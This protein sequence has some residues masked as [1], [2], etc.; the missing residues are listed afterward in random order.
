MSADN[1]SSVSAGEDQQ[2]LAI[3]QRQQVLQAEQEDTQKRTFS[4]WINSQLLK[5]PTRTV[6]KEL[7]VDIQDGHILLDLLEV[8]S[9]EQ[10]PRE[11]GRN[12][13]QSRS[14]IASSLS[15]LEKRSIKLINI[16]VE[17]I[18][19]GKPSIV[20]GLIWQIIIHFHIEG[21]ASVLA[22]T[23]D[24]QTVTCDS[25]SVVS[26]TASPLPKRSAKSRW[27][28]S[29]KKILLQ[30]A[31]ERCA[32]AGSINVTD[33]KSSWKNGQAL[34]A[35]IHSLRP[36][37]VDMEK[38][39]VKSN[40][41][42]LQE[43]FKI[44]EEELKIPRL[45]EP[46]DFNVSDPDEKSIM[47]YVAQ[48]L[49]YSKNMEKQTRDTSGSVSKA[50]EWLNL[51]EQTLK[52]LFSEM[53]DE[54]YTNKYQEIL[55]FMRKFNE[56]KRIYL[57]DQALNALKPD[58]Q[59]LIKQSIENI[60]FQIAQWKEQLDRSLPAPLDAIE[61]WLSEIENL[62][63]QTLPE[64]GSHY[65]TMSL[66]QNLSG[67]LKALMSLASSHLES[68]TS[69]KN[70]DD[71]G[72]VLVPTDKTE[73]MKTRMEKI[74]TSN[75]SVLLDYRS[76]GHYV[77]AL[78]EEARPKL[79][80][81]KG[82]YK[83]Q[84]MVEM[85]LK[86]YQE[87]VDDKQFMVHLENAFQKFKELHN[88]LMATDEYL[89]DSEIAQQYEMI[90][91]KYK[92]FATSAQD[93][94]SAMEKVLT[95]WTQFENNMNL[96]TA[97]LDEQHKT[98]PGHA[99]VEIL[100]KWKS[101]HKSLNR[102]CNFLI[103]AT[104]DKMA[105]KLTHRLK[106]LNSRW[107]KYL[108]LYEEQRKTGNSSDTHEEQSS[109]MHERGS[110][111][112][113]DISAQ[114]LRKHVQT[115]QR[116]VVRAHQKIQELLPR[117]DFVLHP[118]EPHLSEKDIKMNFEMSKGDLEHYIT[119]AM[120][121]LGQRVTPEEFISQYEKNLKKFNSQNLNSFLNAAKQMKSIS[122]SAKE[123]LVVDEIS[124][125]LRCR[126][127][128]VYDELE[129]Y[130][131]ELKLHIE[132]KTVNPSCKAVDQPSVDMDSQLTK[133]H[134]ISVSVH[135]NGESTQK[136]DHADGFTLETMLQILEE[137]KHDLE[138]LL[139]S[140]REKLLESPQEAQDISELQSKL[141]ELQTLEVL[142]N[143]QWR[144]LETTSLSAEILMNA[145]KRKNFSETRYKL[146]SEMNSVN[147]ELASRVHSLSV[148]ISVLLPFE[149]E[150]S[151]L[152]ESNL[153][154]PAQA[155]EKF[156]V[157]NIGSV[158]QEIKAFQ[159]SV[160]DQ[161]QQCDTLESAAVIDST[162]PVNGPVV[163]SFVQQ[164]KTQLEA[165]SDTMKDRQILLKDLQNFLSSLSA[166][167]LSIQSAAA[168]SG[169]DK[170]TILQKQQNL[171]LLEL[172]VHRLRQVATELD[173]QLGPANIYLEDPEQ[174]GATSCK[175][176]VDGF[177]SRIEIVRQVIVQELRALED[178]EA[179]GLLTLNGTVRSNF[180][181]DHSVVPGLKDQS[182]EGEI[183]CFPASKINLVLQEIKDVS[184]TFKHEIQQCDSP[185]DPNLS[186]Y[187]QELEATAEV[188]RDREE[189]L[190]ALRHFLSNLEAAKASV[191]AESVTSGVGRDKLEMKLGN[192]EALRIKINLLRQEAEKLDGCLQTADIALEDPEYGGATSCLK[193]IS[194]FFDKLESTKRALE[195]ELQILEEENA[196]LDR[197]KAMY[198]GIEEVQQQADK[199]GLQDPT[200]HALQ[201][202]IK[203]LSKLEKNLECFAEEKMAIFDGIQKLQKTTKA[204]H[205][206]EW[207]ECEMLWED[208]VQ[209]IATSKEQCEV[210]IKLLRDFQSYKTKLM[211]LIQNAET[212]LS[213]QSSYMGKENLQTFFA[214]VQDMKQE[215]D[216]HS[217]GVEELSSICKKLQ[218]QIHKI[219][220]FEESPFQDEA[221]TIIDKCS[222]LKENVFLQITEKLDN[223]NENLGSIIHR[224]SK[225]QNLSNNIEQWSKM[226]KDANDKGD[227]TKEEALSLNAEVADQERHLE[228]IRKL[229]KEIQNLLQSDELPFE[230][231]V[232]ESSLQSKISLLSKFASD[233]AKNAES[234]PITSVPNPPTTCLKDEKLV[235]HV[236]GTLVTNTTDDMSIEVEPEMEQ[237]VGLQ[238]PTPMVSTP[239]SIE[240]QTK[241]P[242]DYS[243]VQSELLGN[244]RVRLSKLKKKKESL[245][246][247]PQPGLQEK[248]KQLESFK[249]L[250]SENM[251]LCAA[252]KALKSHAM[253]FENWEEQWL[254]LLQLNEI[255]MEDLQGTV[256]MLESCVDG[257]RQY[258][259]FSTAL[260]NKMT[261]FNEDLLNFSSSSRENAPCEQ[262]RRKLQELRDQYEILQKDL[263]Q[264][265]QVSEGVKQSTS[266]SGVTRIQGALD[267]CQ[268]K[269]KSF[270]E[271]LDYLKQAIELPTITSKPQK[272]NT[273]KVTK[274]K[275]EI[276]VQPQLEPPSTNQTMMSKEEVLPHV[277]FSD[278]PTG[279]LPVNRTRNH[280]ETPASEMNLGEELCQGLTVLDHSV[281]P[282]SEGLQGLNSETLLAASAAEKPSP[283][284]TSALLSP[285]TG[286]SL[287]SATGQVS[288]VSGEKPKKKKSK[289]GIKVKTEIYSIQPTTEPPL[290]QLSGKQIM[291]SKEEVLPEPLEEFSK[292]S[293]V[294][295][296]PSAN[297]SQ[298]PA[299]ETNLILAYAN[300]SGQLTSEDP[301]SL[302]SE[303][304]L[305]SPAA[306]NHLTTALALNS[307]LPGEPSLLPKAETSP[308]PG[309][310]LA[311]ATVKVSPVTVEKTKKTKKGSKVKTEMRVQPPLESLV[312]QPSENQTIPKGEVSPQLLEYFDKPSE[313]LVPPVAVNHLATTASALVS[314]LPGKPLL[315]PMAET[316]SV[317]VGPLEHVTCVQVSPV[318]VEKTKKTKKSS[319]MRTEINV[320]PQLEPLLLQPGENQTIPEREVSSQL[321]VES[322]DKPTEEL[323]IKPSTNNLET[324]ST[325]MNLRE[326][327][328]LEFATGDHSEQLTFE[329]PL[330]SPSRASQV[331]ASADRS[332]PSGEPLVPATAEVSVPKV[333]GEYVLPTM[334][335]VS[336]SL[337]SGEFIVPAT[338]ETSVSLVSEESLVPATAEDAVSQLQVETLVPATADILVSP[339]PG[340]LA[341]ANVSIPPVLRE[342]VMPGTLSSSVPAP[343]TAKAPIQFSENSFAGAVLHGTTQSILPPSGEHLL[344]SVQGSPDAL[345]TQNKF[346]SEVEHPIHSAAELLKLSSEEPFDALELPVQPTT[347][348]SL[349]AAHVK[350]EVKANPMQDAIEHA[351]HVVENAV[352]MALAH[353]A[354]DL[355]ESES[356]N[357]ELPMQPSD[358]TTDQ[359]LVT[360]RATENVKQRKSSKG[361]KKKK[362]LV[363]SCPVVDHE[364]N[365]LISPVLKASTQDPSEEGLNV[366]HIEKKMNLA[367]LDSLRGSGKVVSDVKEESP[368]ATGQ[369]QILLHDCDIY[370][371]QLETLP[372]GGNDSLRIFALLTT[373]EKRLNQL[374][375]LSDDRKLD[376]QQVSD[377]DGSCFNKDTSDMQ[378][379][380][381]FRELESTSQK[382]LPYYAQFQEEIK[383]ILSNI[384]HIG[385]DQTQ[386]HNTLEKL[387][388]QYKLLCMMDG[389]NLQPEQSPQG[390]H[391]ALLEKNISTFKTQQFNL[392]VTVLE[393]E[394]QDIEKLYDYISQLEFQE[395]TTLREAPDEP[396]QSSELL[397]SKREDLLHQLTALK[398]E[399]KILCQALTKF[400]DALCNARQ[401]YQML[402]KE[403]E[404]LKM[405]PTESHETY[406]ARITC[407]SVK[408]DE[409]K[410]IL[411][412]LK[413]EQANMDGFVFSNEDKEKIVSD[414]QQ[415]EDL[416]EQLEC[417]VQREHDRLTKEAEELAV[418]REKVNY[419]QNIIQGQQD[420]LDQPSP[421]AEDVLKASLGVSADVET[422]KHSF[423]LLRNSCDLQMK[424]T[425][426]S[427]ERQ[428]LENSLDT[429][430]KELESLEERVK[431]RQ[432]TRFQTPDTILDQWQFLKSLYKSYLWVRKCQERA[433]SDQ[434]IA[435]LLENLEKQIIAYKNV[436]RGISDKKSSLESAIEE[437]KH[438][439]EGFNLM[440]SKDFSSFF[441]K[442]QELY[443]EQFIKSTTRLQQLELGQE[444]RKVL[445]SEIEKLKKLLQC[446]EKEATPVIRGIFSATELCEQLNCL[447]A[448]ATE[449][450]E[451]EGLVLTL[452]RNSQSYH[453]ELKNSEQ[454]YLNDV[455]RS[456]KAKARRIRRFEEKT[457]SYTKKLL[458][459][460]N[461]FKE[462]MTFLHHHINALQPIEPKMDDTPLDKDGFENKLQGSQNAI[463]S[464][465]YLS[466]MLNYKELFEENGLY[467]DVS[468]MDNLKKS[469]SAL[470][471]NEEGAGYLKHFGT[472]QSH[473]Q[474]LLE[475]IR[476]MVC[477]LQKESANVASDFDVVAATV[478]YKKVGDICP[479]ITEALD[480]NSKQEAS[481]DT[482]SV[483]EQS[484]K[485]LSDNMNYLHQTVGNVITAYY[486]ANKKESFQHQIKQT[487]YN[488]N[489]I[490]KEFQK[491]FVNKLDESDTHVR[492]ITLK[493][494]AEI[495]TTELQSIRLLGSLPIDDDRKRSEVETLGKQVMEKITEHINTTKEASVFLQNFQE[496]S[497]NVAEHF[498]QF[499][500]KLQ[501]DHSDLSH[502]A[503]QMEIL[504]C[505]RE[506][507]DGAIGVVH[508]IAAQLKSF[509]SVNDQAALDKLL[510][511]IATKK[512][513]LTIMW[514][515]KQSA[516]ASWNKSH[517][518]FKDYKQK[519]HE[520]LQEVEMDIRDTFLRKPTSYKA[521]L[522]QWE[523]SKNLTA[524]IQSYEEDLLKLQKASEELLRNNGDNVLL[525]DKIMASLWDRWFYLL[526]ISRD[527]ELYC[528]EVKQD[529]KLVSELMEREMILLDNCQEE[530]LDNPEVKQPTFQLQST[531][532]DLKRFEENMEMQQLQL[533]L[534][535]HRI[536]NILG[537]ESDADLI[538]VISEIQSMEAK[539]EGLLHKAH[540]NNQEIHAEL[541]GREGL[542]DDISA[543]KKSAQELSST[544][545]N[546]EIT[547]VTEAKT[548]LE[549]L[550][551]LTLSEKEKAKIIMEKLQERYAE[552]VPAELLSHA[553]ECQECLL[554]MEEKVTNEIKQCSPHNIITRKVNEIK[555]GLQDIESR[556]TKKSENIFQAK[557]L[558]K[559]V[560]D[561]VDGWHSKLHALESEIQDMAEEDPSQAQA[562]MDI[563]TEPFNYY[564]QV[565]YLVERRTVNLNKA[566]S[567]L[568]EY[569]EF[570]KSII[571]WIQNTNSLLNEEMKDSSAKVLNKHFNA[572]AMAL[573]DSEQKQQL[574]DTMSS[575]LGV[576][577]VIFETDNTVERLNEVR[578]QVKEL[579]ERILTVLPQIQIFANEVVTIEN[580]VKRMEKS[581][582][583]IKT[584]LTSNEIDDMPPI[585]HH[586]NGQVIL[587][588]ID[589][590]RDT[591]ANIAAYRP[592]LAA[593]ARGVQS[594]YVFKRMRRLLREAEILEKV[595]K[596]QNEL[597]EPIVQEMSELEQE[598]ERLKHLS[599]NFTHET[600][601]IKVRAD[602]LRNQLEGLN[603]NKEAILLSQRSSIIQQ[604]THLELEPQDQD[605]EDILSPV[606]EGV[607][608]IS[609]EGNKAVFLPSVVE[610]A[611]ESILTAEA[612]DKDITDIGLDIDLKAE[613]VSDHPTA[614]MTSDQL[615]Q[616]QLENARQ[617]L[618]DV[619][620][621][622]ILSDCQGKVTKVEL[623]LQAVNLS[624]AQGEEEP[625]MLQNVEQQ[626]SDCQKT[627]QE[628]EKK[629]NSLLEDADYKEEGHGSVLEEAES[630]ARKLKGLK[631]SLENVQV[632]LQ[633]KPGA[634]QG[635]S[636]EITEK[637]KAEKLVQNQEA[638]IPSQTRH[639][640]EVL[641]GQARPQGK[642]CL[643]EDI[644]WSKWQY[645]QKE[646]SHRTKAV[647]LKP[648]YEPEAEKERKVSFNSRLPGRTIKTPLMDDA[649]HL[650]TRLQVLSEEAAAPFTQASALFVWLCSVSQWLQKVEGV[651]DADISQEDAT[652]ELARCE[653]LSDD[654]NT[655]SEEM[656]RKMETLLK[657]ITHEGENIGVLSQCYNDIRNWLVQTHSVALS[658]AKYIREEMEKHNNYQNDIRRMYDMLVKKKSDCIQQLDNRSDREADELLKESLAWDG[659]LQNFDSQVSVLN[660][661]G[662]MF[663]INAYSN[664]EIDK[665]EDVLDDTWR[666]IITKQGQYSEAAIAKSQTDSLLRGVS[667]LVDVGKEKI[668]KSKDYKFRSKESLI[669]HTED[670]KKF[671]SF[672]DGQVLL[673][674]A[675]SSQDST[676]AHCRRE[677]KTVV[678][679]A[680]LLGQKAEAH[681]VHLMGIVKEWDEFDSRYNDLQKHFE[682]LESLV[683]TKT[684][685]EESEERVND[686]IKQ[687]QHIKE[688]MDEKESDFWQVIVTGKRLQSVV[689]FEDL[690]SRIQ[691][692]EQ[693]WSLLTKKVNHELHRLESLGS[694]LA[695]YNKK[696]AELVSWLKSAHQQLSTFK[697]Q[698]L[699]ASQDLDTIRKNVHMFFEFT[700]LVDEKSSLKTSVLSTG[701]QLLRL[702]EADT[703]MLKVK[704]SK[705]EEQWTELISSLPPIQ[706][707]LQQTIDHDRT[708]MLSSYVVLGSYFVKLYT[709][710]NFADADVVTQN[711]AGSCCIK[712]LMEKLSSLQAIDE[713][714]D[715]MGKYNTDLQAVDD[716]AASVS[717]IR[718]CLQK[719]KTLR[720]EMSVKQWVVDFVNQSLLQLSVGDVESQRYERTEFAELLGSLNLQ[721][722]K[723]Q[724][725]LNRKIQQEEQTL[726]RV[727]DQESKRQSISNWFD[728]QQVR[729][730]KLQRPSSLTVAESALAECLHLEEQ[731][732]AKSTLIEELERGEEVAGDPSSFGLLTSTHLGRK[733]DA[734]FSKVL[735]KK[736]SLLS[737]LKHWKL[738]VKKYDTLQEML[739]KLLYLIDQAKR[740]KS[741]LHCI[742][743]QLK[744]L[745][746]AQEEVEQHRENWSEIKAS[747]HGMKGHC[748]PKIFAT[749]EKDY[750]EIQNRW[751]A[752]NEALCSQLQSSSLLLQL[753]EAYSSS[754]QDHAL[755]MKQ[756]QEKCQQLLFSNLSEDREADTLQQRIKDLQVFEQGLQGLR[757]HN[758]QVSELAD[759]VI[760][761]NPAAAD[762]IHSE[763]QNTSH[764]IDHLERSVSSKAAELK[765]LQNEVE[766]FKKDLVKLQSDVKSSADFVGYVCLS[767]KEKQE[768]SEGIKKHLLEL[769]EL[770][771][772]IEHLNEATLTLPLDD[773][774]L[775]SLQNLNRSWEKTGEMA[776]EDCRELRAI[777][778]E[779]NNFI[780]NNEAWIQCLGKMESSLTEGIAGTF[781][782]LQKQQ[783][784]YERLQAE[785]AIN[786]HILP[787]FVNKTL[788]VLESE[789]EE[790]RSEVI[791][792]LTTLK[793]KW[794]NVIRLVQQ[795]NREINVLLKQWWH[796]TTSKQRLEKHLSGV[797][798]ALASIGPQKCHSLINA[799]KL[800]FDFKE[801]Q[802]HVKRLQPVYNTAVESCKDLLS[803]AEL[804]CKE[805][806][807]YHLTELQD[808]WQNT[809]LQLQAALRHFDDTA[810]KKEQFEQYVEDRRT[811]LHDL[812]LS[813][814][815]PLPV[816]YEEL[817]KSK[818]SIK[819][820]E[821]ALDEWGDSLKELDNMK[822]ELSQ[823]IVAEDGVVL[824][825]Q[826]ETLHRQWEE[827]CLRVSMR[828]QEIE[829]RLNAWNVF[830]EKNK[831]LC[832][833]LTQMESKALQT[834]DVN[835]EEMIE[836]LQKDCMEE[837]NL[838][839]ENK[840][841]L[842]QIGD[843]LI[844]ASNK[845][846]STEIENKLNKVNDRWK[847]LFDV[848]GSRVKKLKETLVIIQQLDKNMSNLRTW[849]ARIE[850]ELSKPVIYSICDDQEI[851]R[852]LEEQKDLQ[853]DIELHSAGVASVLNICERLLHDTDAC[854]SETECDSIQQTTRSLDKRWRNICTMSM[855]RRLRI[856][857][858]WRLWQKFLEDYSKFDDWL[859]E[860]EAMAAS[861][862][863]SDV[864]YTKA[865][866][867]QKKF[868]AFQRQIHER[869]TH[870]ELI[871]KQYRRLAREN[872]TDAA[873]RLKQMV[874]EGNRRWDHL[875]R[876]VAAIL[877]RLKHFTSQRE[878]FEGTRDCILVWLTEMDLQLT[879]VEHFS[880]SDIQEKMQQLVGF[881]QEITLNT[882]KIDQLI[883]FGEQL[884]QKSEAMDAV[885]IEDELEE[886]HRYCQEVFG[887]VYR[888]H[889]RLTAKDMNLEEERETS[890]NDTDGEDSREIQNSSWHSTIPDVDTSHQSLCQLM[891][892]P[893]PHERSGCETPV[894][895]DSI[896]LEWDPTV[897][898]GGSSMHENEEESTYYNPLSDVEIPENP[899]AYV[900]MT[901]KTVQASSGKSDIATPTWHSPDKHVTSS[902][903][904]YKGREFVKGL[905]SA[906]TAQ[907]LSDEQASNSSPSMN[908]NEGTS[909]AAAKQ[910][911]DRGLQGLY[912]PETHSGVIERW[913]ILHAQ[914]LSNKR[915]AKQSAQQWQ[916]FYSEL[917]NLTHWLEKTE[918]ELNSTE[919]LKPSR[920]IQELEQKVKNLKDTLKAFDHYKAL[921]LSTN[922][923][924]EELQQAEDMES[925]ELL[926]RLHEVNGHWDK[927]CHK[928]DKWR[929]NL[930]EDLAQCEEFH[931]K[932]HQLLLWLTEAESRRI[933]IQ[934]TDSRG[935]P[936]ALLG[937]Q[938]QL[939][940]LEEQLL[941]RQIEADALQ[942]LSNQ[943]LA[944]SAGDSYI[945]AD[946]RTHVIATKM[947]QVLKQVSQ[948]LKDVQQ[949]LDS[950]SLDD[951]DSARSTTDRMVKVPA[952]SK[953]TSR[954][955]KSDRTQEVPKKPSLFYRVLRA[956]LPL[957][958][959]LLLLLL[960][961][962]MI[963][964][965]EEDYSC[966]QANN[967][968]RSFYPMLRYTNGPPPT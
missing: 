217:E 638:I 133:D 451:I 357:K 435:L 265:S 822:S 677:E 872:R 575:E 885:V 769:R 72:V 102:D 309:G 250:I 41:E 487:L 530:V 326:V 676:S 907:G 931:E 713:L 59:Q 100:S 386:T 528:D 588:N 755:H 472:N 752:A 602:E 718:I 192:L 310:P 601:D 285:A 642:H 893:P 119:S 437:S 919:K 14:N 328:P 342:A 273:K 149:Q 771:A 197:Q 777:E 395:S 398:M 311:T 24:L 298:M 76:S 180:Q 331:P 695:G 248:I 207:E 800:F 234:L 531:V 202:R 237:N 743:H 520:R 42:K 461:E 39:L 69:F 516:L 164:Y 48:F 280:L 955:R 757:A 373:I 814:D 397:L 245:G 788:S 874:H 889:E 747:L 430:Q 6:V 702:K 45:L 681:C 270:L 635:H 434:T 1:G 951:I 596:E 422:I 339:I 261:S 366:E 213:Q 706:E 506:E 583:S 882:N 230:L 365:G 259:L 256:L 251:D 68:L 307:P 456:L 873:S 292:K 436:C 238:S 778:L 515:R 488:L 756:L 25:K 726:E 569:E 156:T 263:A 911:E 843:Q 205:F 404:N 949:S 943:L 553:E 176:M 167:K 296:N 203:Y 503:E 956:A 586:R 225:I 139:Q 523:K 870:L 519:I 906:A 431:D 321:L 140:S 95:C 844:D 604:L 453:G 121:L 232:A 385:G 345:L 347:E 463:L 935:D 820:L 709:T 890:E 905:V 552:I 714:M 144:Q 948:D 282:K 660:E 491:P 896:P 110:I 904:N 833:W 257:H 950:C 787:S 631:I 157:S 211:S 699:D 869:L 692:A 88:Q 739:I 711:I 855:E 174:G 315:K 548:S 21:L 744:R 637:N 621:E 462:K 780:Q 28:T 361:Q 136:E 664:Q 917:N 299:L 590:I 830:N 363:A 794:Q 649:T 546:L 216:G 301:P 411:L 466:Q 417:S 639:S 239:Q 74:L 680:N 550:L 447:K 38:F 848:I 549:E 240:F 615:S 468:A 497:F 868:E 643:S 761:Q 219:K 821:D 260:N 199:I 70:V 188:W 840:L 804:E 645:L 734:L 419:I 117:L 64:S 573:D 564:Q 883:V 15:F 471:L 665:L 94:K 663:S 582:N 613:D 485:M 849:L 394:I 606:T 31:Q 7:Y 356:K 678:H 819:E 802:R 592:I 18:I 846:R 479:L 418:V 936:N 22:A 290:L 229:S 143:Q 253:D 371:R 104:N 30:W 749:M 567:K 283:T 116:N 899:E 539:C 813:V 389:D 401:S 375:M 682:S 449:M 701:N 741:S 538:P 23:D 200:I 478:L 748:S 504:E 465:V 293:A 566:T 79:K 647:P 574:L 288:L 517:L 221:N 380:S 785:I 915:C 774:T 584:I 841:H 111:K 953:D 565:T 2:Q 391:L 112:Q 968:A 185:S 632:M 770:S 764:R 429:L 860:A 107:A 402:S 161:I 159:C 13:F 147:E 274:K 427:S 525:V 598:Q 886:L 654:L 962:C 659:E 235:Q 861:P 759:K 198:K 581:V 545:E 945:E 166:T 189:T 793:E 125:D 66:L 929:E 923:L 412:T 610:E 481:K 16:H 302:P 671:F 720:K 542:M 473:Y 460:C 522:E 796:F 40:E 126:W 657:S 662:R 878:D 493:T 71:D 499:E 963:P 450:E 182:Q 73:E 20:L 611:E 815:E 900:L 758:L 673:L 286:E 629:I 268:C 148:T 305:V 61:S 803:V 624:L 888:F 275:S 571:L 580:E 128:R 220:S 831:E 438:I 691:R 608:S 894:S 618:A 585:E 400:E 364:T 65:N 816:L 712:L 578:S 775:S 696:T 196:L 26:P 851:N 536:K 278:L 12:V 839:S 863:S 707:K 370:R 544:L 529:W 372:D 354:Q 231:Q 103:E 54:T 336:V 492:L 393:R 790:Q 557:E 554:E 518:L 470:K 865:K 496:A 249:N 925:K 480:L 428:D 242:P 685:V 807:Q 382:V 765:L 732:T 17:D 857:E 350:I 338:D 570:L 439:S 474:K 920:S 89:D 359:L 360:S 118:L 124:A 486:A 158:C 123:K 300:E 616:E 853:K 241:S 938:R 511:Q 729:L 862:G 551:K 514:E 625:E 279:E 142:I 600:P 97:W 881:K 277:D 212:L 483:E 131:N 98:Q 206:I 458:S 218:S 193:L 367:D 294:S 558:Q 228:E 383:E 10:L 724:G 406:L 96:I 154:T 201:Q 717:D 155:M 335:E 607:S 603:Q 408:L 922:L 836:K 760:R 620:P 204:K 644:T 343:P 812:K 358:E 170:T 181:A 623:W 295:I 656:R 352:H 946:E 269:M 135:Q 87:F 215:Y 410:I 452:L 351:V 171:G 281:Q 317:P 594:L 838:F 349:E 818:T 781:E 47:T 921:V 753:W 60:T 75:F 341:D 723:M 333:S 940:Q 686:R 715:W 114:S 243:E 772:D 847:H 502:F 850:S 77:L 9:G 442:L 258:D 494:L 44:A 432:L 403:K 521:A 892:P 108:K 82:K 593:S 646:L 746:S 859:K 210:V 387:C 63:S 577:A 809:T 420:L 509:C 576:L 490:D 272:K 287:V 897:D 37:L 99:P 168:D 236:N 392:N 151:V 319:R 884:I 362:L 49:Q 409:E 834:A 446:R 513:V 85:M 267:I 832:D 254:E 710:D 932:S 444:R 378:P 262:K 661:R 369:L 512:S 891:P 674:Q 115:L 226:K 791:L 535:K 914:N 927:A 768:R 187:K 909:G 179:S 875:Q 773:R 426:G 854:A 424:R 330:T 191:E 789:E 476:K 52:K 423:Y 101:V 783:K 445:F 762:V 901:T 134:K 579:Q 11:K 137:Q 703:S 113:T 415:I 413:A 141:Q 667:D 784:I 543:V 469:L 766:I 304:P 407:F 540:R 655:L 651:L 374:E 264:V 533:L 559:K 561:E 524:K 323:V 172:E 556:L 93:A 33:F 534:L 877:R 390:R 750:V 898:V 8:L 837:I 640:G 327:I 767:Q 799:R 484:L 376:V 786:E 627:L 43:A 80:A 150:V 455:L 320:Q 630:L 29:A 704:Q 92:T 572:L 233:E 153:Q 944:S 227:L 433:S 910:S 208:A 952:T 130:V 186:R 19:S 547:D 498:R 291:M 396:G 132:R 322:L 489:S 933:D 912:N 313:G 697:A 792:K 255:F 57:A 679:K 448:K 84:E 457:F 609:K 934:A 965:S 684:L 795:R 817:Q 527:W 913:E 178:K 779:R 344:Q 86:D 184:H 926:G 591:V 823:Y 880:E 731:M 725:E 754:Y 668:L 3:D 887:R 966:A 348:T 62:M 152:C 568:E 441:Q 5:H 716:A 405:A 842:K 829:D 811:S 276:P 35:I 91:S 782:A 722:N 864:L 318:M 827:L 653:K 27:K 599:K 145:S 500:G 776:L 798:A 918:A 289:K 930:Q 658:R 244:L 346:Q 284:T 51:E 384:S 222:V 177:F 510:N 626:L 46:E 957:Q 537:A 742:K 266:P 636:T 32:Q 425:W 175:K 464:Q 127:K 421:S 895:V 810:L 808:L 562:C 687:Y 958:L 698:S 612:V 165:T 224:W 705:F 414:V 332:S 902:T 967:F 828:K 316:P 797:Q 960:L 947:R 633:M 719:Y 507:L 858:T 845:A 353:V 735:E 597:L 614:H 163:Q 475:K 477:H 939:M 688:I 337:V 58:E 727:S 694:H 751:T 959:L 109:C 271:R 856:E 183:S 670:H 733:R 50:T 628:T 90:E 252:L 526:D 730:N 81:W 312:L 690:D 247:D 138:R 825:K 129:S 937:C 34:L 459:I 120:A 650:L 805:D 954:V 738:Y 903:P 454:L 634:E 105:S 740:P 495:C 106:S 297:I 916:Q 209:H 867:E 324:P 78:L 501:M 876:R 745:Q 56:Q 308:V 672:L 83:S 214:K 467:W 852:K 589:S 190:K 53:K 666:F 508:N 908:K 595:T 964:F 942:N 924:S 826:V 36:D 162:S 555:T 605:Q 4:K 334:T 381:L 388:Y 689:N 122:S 619:K 737:L 440:V 377:E 303:V 652:S 532:D 648:S 617:T 928:R 246:T 443:Q 169:M 379:D 835:I 325:Q 587:Q 505:K 728:G 314:V 866:E 708:D 622:M 824:R 560:W 355:E 195:H 736:T 693:Q 146:Q 961:A 306:V 641:S 879:N 399:K 801:K 194:V 683:P 340:E 669:T 763:R 55:L 416:W 700:C 563:L 806:L 223:Y 541:Q 871:N 675:L 160:E 329:A 941:E 721:W 368:E 67:S 482:L 173:D